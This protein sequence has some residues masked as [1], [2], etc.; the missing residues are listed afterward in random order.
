MGARWRG[1]SQHARPGTLFHVF[2]YPVRWCHHRPG[3][4]CPVLYSVPTTTGGFCKG[5]TL[6]GGDVPRILSPRPRPLSGGAFPGWISE[7]PPP[8]GG[9][10]SGGNIPGTCTTFR[11]AF[12]GVSVSGSPFTFPA[13][14]TPFGV[15][16]AGCSTGYPFRDT[17][18]I[19]R[20]HFFG[21]VLLS[22]PPGVPPRVPYR[23]R[24]VSALFPVPGNHPAG[25][26]K[27]RT[28]P[29]V[30]SGTYP[31]GVPVPTPAG[32]P[33]GGGCPRG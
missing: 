18:A 32:L 6:S 20:P 2:G 13:P 31:P 5:G 19:H 33:G 25:Y 8:F 3:C 23:K 12:S 30:T 24:G 10:G 1:V 28:P 21:G 26:V 16:G 27:V 22:P 29:G 11:G 9:I 7:H 17:P 4:F 15:V 14:G